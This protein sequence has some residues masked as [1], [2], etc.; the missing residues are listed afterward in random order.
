MRYIIDIE[1]DG[2]LDIVSRIHVASIY[3]CATKETISIFGRI[4]ITNFFSSLTLNDTI[5]GHI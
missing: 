3:N 1:A 4:N 2:L 5:I